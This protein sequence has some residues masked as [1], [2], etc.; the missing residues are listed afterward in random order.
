[1]T[2]EYPERR[3]F[4]GADDEF[5][6][7]VTDQVAR[8]FRLAECTDPELGTDPH[9]KDAHAFEA[10]RIMSWLCEV[11]A[12]WAADHEVGLAIE[13]RQFLVNG[14]L[15]ARKL[16]GFIEDQA[17]VDSHR[18]E[19]VGRNI[20]RY[21]TDVAPEAMRLAILNVLRTGIGG[22]PPS[23]NTSLTDAI[24]A[25]GL[26][27][28]QPLLKAKKSSRKVTLRQL[29][30]QL[31]AIGFIAYRQALGA[32]QFA[33][34]EDI[35]SAYGVSFDTVRGWEPRIRKELGSRR[36]DNERIGAKNL[37]SHVLL[38]RKQ[39]LKGQPFD[40][41]ASSF[42]NRHNDAALATVGT[43]YR[44]LVGRPDEKE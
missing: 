41:A 27:E 16:P 40:A 21:R 11:L 25:L 29:R 12:G 19:I 14:P 2:F 20:R 10:L 18:H 15:D 23:I 3:T 37:A 9:R 8:L 42:G 34:I 22:L 39:H 38:A 30:L 26:G 31:R 7:L 5:R 28:V 6:K 35:A 32:S 36:V 44:I 1:M 13:G 43:E 24:E 4:Q 17:E 33:A